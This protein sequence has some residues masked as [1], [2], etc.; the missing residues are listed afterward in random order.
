MSTYVDVQV[1]VHIQLYIILN[2]VTDYT[3]INFKGIHFVNSL[4]ICDS[5]NH[6]GEAY[7]TLPSLPIPSN[8][9]CTFLYFGIFFKKCFFIKDGNL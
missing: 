9:M 6:S 8:L 5:W 3:Y 4:Q 2:Y 7:T 1:E